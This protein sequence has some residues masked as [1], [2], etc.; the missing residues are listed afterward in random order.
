MAL[1]RSSVVQAKL[2]P[3]QLIRLDP[4]SDPPEA[5]LLPPQPAIRAG[6]DHPAACR[7]AAPAGPASKAGHLF[8][9]GPIEGQAFHLVVNGA[10]RRR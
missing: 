10:R 2:V 4:R 3:D 8:T 9:R 7:R 5:P 1:L 6:C